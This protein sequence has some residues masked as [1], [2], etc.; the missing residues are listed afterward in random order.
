MA[1]QRAR[2]PPPKASNAMEGSSSEASLSIGDAGASPYLTTVEAARYLRYRG[3]SA[4]RNLVYRGLLHPTG[5]RGRTWLFLVSD[6]DDM[7]R[8]HGA[9]VSPEGA[10]HHAE[11]N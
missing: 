5:R 3:P 2:N 7:I 6:L 10:V 4:I 11:K 1:G 8:S 9:P